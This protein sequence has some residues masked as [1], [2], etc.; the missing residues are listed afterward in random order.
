MRAGW[1][2][3][4]VQDRY[5]RYENAGDHYLGRVLSGLPQHSAKFALLPPHF[6]LFDD[7]VSEAI[8]LSFMG[9]PSSMNKVLEMCLASVVYHFDFVMETIPI[10]HPARSSYVLSNPDVIKT[11]R[12]LISCKMTSD[13]PVPI[14]ATGIPPHIN[15]L[16]E[17]QLVADMYKLIP[18]EIV[19]RIDTMLDDKGIAA[20][21]VTPS[22]LQEVIQTS[23]NQA[24]QSSGIMNLV[25]SKQQA[26]NDGSTA[27]KQW[28]QWGGSFKRL[29]KTFKW[30]RANMESCWFLWWFGNDQMGYPPFRKITP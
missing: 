20:G 8:Q 13:S 21:N 10:T 28:Y 30:P 18:D 11:L 9:Y 7:Q 19:S 27:T 24:L 6:T 22:M 2:I 15:L 29:P 25:E 23:L 4:G 16:R 12:P 14:T 5:F 17:I 1:K 26:N 3:G